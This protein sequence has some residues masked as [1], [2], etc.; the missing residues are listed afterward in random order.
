MFY[1]PEV[2]TNVNSIDFGTTQLGGKLGMY[3]FMAIQMHS[4][5]CNI[6]KRNIYVKSCFA[7]SVKLP[8]WAYSPVDFIHKHRMAL[9]SEHVSAHL[10]EWIDL[11]FGYVSYV[12]I[13]YLAGIMLS[14]LL[15]LQHQ[16]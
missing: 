11:I 14:L 12:Q 6:C 9:E 1:L 16:M 2:L 3:I 8:P 7:D 10:H 13:V 5:L 4:S 15:P